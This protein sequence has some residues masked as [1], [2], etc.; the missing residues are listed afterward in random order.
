MITARRSLPRMIRPSLLLAALLLL[1]AQIAAA[2]PAV[3]LTTDFSLNNEAVGLCHGAILAVDADLAIVDLCHTIR[4]FDI[5]QAS[6]ALKRTDI[7]PSGTVFVT[8]VDPGVGTARGAVAVRTRGGRIHVA[9]DNGVLT[10]VIAREGVVQAA[11][12]DPKRVNPRWKPGTFDGRD[13]FS[14]AGALLAANGGTFERIGR[15]IPVSDLV[16]LPALEVKVTAG[17]GRI[18]GHFIRS[19]EPYGN[20]WTDIGPDH[21]RQAGLE[22]GDR[23]RLTFGDRTL[24]LPFVTTFGEVPEGRPLAYLDS[25]GGLAFALNQGNFVKTHDWREGLEIS[26]GRC[27]SLSRVP[28]IH[29]VR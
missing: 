11:R 18:T 16:R 20:A 26:V 24:E 25:D 15:P 9:P 12:I 19:D 14:P 21:L 5:R 6:L 29:G 10:E 13:L 28:G 27:A 17:Q 23:L 4:P 22:L 3:V 2:R 8:V 7:F 1:F